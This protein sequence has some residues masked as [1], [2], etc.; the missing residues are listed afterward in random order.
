MALLQI[1]SVPISGR[2]YQTIGILANAC[3]LLVVAAL[4]SKESLLEKGMRVPKGAWLMGACTD[5]CVG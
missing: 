5:G 3:V 1:P 2:T 4:E